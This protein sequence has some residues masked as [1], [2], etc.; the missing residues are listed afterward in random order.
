ML[1]GETAKGDY[2]LETVKTMHFICKDAENSTYHCQYLR[3][4]LAETIL[5]MD[6]TRTTALTA[7]VAALNCHAAAIV[8]VTTAIACSRYKTP[9]PI[10]AVCRQAN[11]CRQLNLCR[12][13]FPVFYSKPRGSDCNADN[14]SRINHGIEFGKEKG[15]INKGDFVVVITGWKFGSGFN[16]TVRVITA[17]FSANIEKRLNQFDVR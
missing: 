1:S 3:D 15:M 7:V 5:P 14:E 4:V 16:N 8:L 12:S 10:L 2:P 13:V 17:S 11:V 9:F 6:M